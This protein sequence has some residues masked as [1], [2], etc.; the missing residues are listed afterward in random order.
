ML[1]LAAC[2]IPVVLSSWLIW[3]AETPAAWE[4]PIGRGETRAVRMQLAAG[5]MVAVTVEQAEIDLTLSVEYPDGRWVEGSDR[6]AYGR[7]TLLFVTGAEGDYTVEIQANPVGARE[8]RYRLS[9]VES[10]R[11]R[12]SDE[13]ALR[14][15][16][17]FVQ[18]TGLDR[19]ATAD[20]QER[21]RKLYRAAA[22]LFRQGGYEELAAHAKNLEGRALDRLGRRDAAYTYYLEALRTRRKIGDEYGQLESL[23]QIARLSGHLKERFSFVPDD[24]GFLEWWRKLGDRRGI[25]HA[26]SVVSSYYR[27]ELKNPQ[28]ATQWAER[29]VQLSRQLGDQVMEARCLES[30]AR[31]LQA[32]GKLDEAMRQASKI[33]DLQREQIGRASCRERV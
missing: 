13:G 3:L 2:L 12:E 1:K 15:Q 24:L 10:R 20:G 28:E 11:V 21:A 27:R 33:L 30:L 14:A 19:L 32:S 18:A 16:D 25:A 5:Q 6:G 26:M 29:S 7:E 22:E 23:L 9:S 17:L 8:G 31:A 4:E